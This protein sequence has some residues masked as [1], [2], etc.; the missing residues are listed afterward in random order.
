MKKA[1]STL[2]GMIAFSA[3]L[4]MATSTSLAS[5]GGRINESST[6]SAGRW[7]DTD[8][9]PVAFKNDEEILD[10][11]RNAKVVS[12]A[13][14]GEGINGIQK[15]LLE[16]NGVRMHAAFRAIKLHKTRIKLKN[17][18]YPNFRDDCRFEIA[19]YRLSRMLGLD[20]VPPVVER[21][22][23]RK[24][25][26][27]QIWVE[28]AMMEK[29]RL[30]AGV[31]PENKKEWR[32]QLQTMYLFDNLIFNLDR[33]QGNFLYDFEWNLWM[34]DH[35]RAFQQGKKL[36]NASM[37]RQCDRNVWKLLEQLDQDVLQTEL[38]SVLSKRQI[39]NLLDRRDQIVE[40]IQKL[41]D[42]N[43]EEIVI[44]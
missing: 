42:R 5:L 25:G 30:V 15:V 38:K 16:K 3:I 28:N 10:F 44:F 39:R 34:I 9:N 21:K 19:A 2:V 7:L 4:F 31:T 8:G 35:T 29:Q 14:V 1:I 37:I 24:K 26:T 13:R 32:R 23:R 43:G 33:N 18:M 6:A 22:I 36:R 12:T 20:N 41:I 11:L 17:R 40:L 27:L